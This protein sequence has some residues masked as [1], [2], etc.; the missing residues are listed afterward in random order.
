VNFAEGMAPSAVNDSARALMASVAKWRDDI[1]G[2]VATGGSGTAYTI[3]SNQVIGSNVSGFTVQF[4]PGTT[5][6]G[7]VTLSVDSQTAKPLRYLTGVDLTAGCLIAGSLYQA[8]YYSSSDEWLLHSFDARQYVIP[9]GGGIPY[10]GTTAPNSA[11]AFPYG[12]AISRATYATLF[13]ICGTT[14]GTGDGSTTF[15]LPDVRGRVIAGYDIMGGTG[16]SRLT[17]ASGMNGTGIGSVGGAQTKTLAEGELPSLTK[18]VTGASATFSTNYVL[19]T[20]FGSGTA[21]S[22]VTSISAGGSGTVSGNVTFSSMGSI[23]F[24]SGTAFG[25]IQPTIALGYIVRII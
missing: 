4:T 5:N 24:G 2:V 14:F 10:L 25:L 1:S 23:S 21:V 13:A 22:A 3:S 17:T 9:I 18:T 16:A 19:Q 15:N 20:A 7:A 6:T 8:T 11:F 12:Q